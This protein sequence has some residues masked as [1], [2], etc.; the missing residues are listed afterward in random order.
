MTLLAAARI[1]AHR[2]VSLADALIAAL[3]VRA[4]AVLLHPLNLL[5]RPQG[6]ILG[7]KGGVHSAHTRNQF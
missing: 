4:G 1:K 3:A 5:G 6:G 7:S 2:Q